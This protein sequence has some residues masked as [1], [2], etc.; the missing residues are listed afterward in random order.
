M[1]TLS[2]L[3]LKRCVANKSLSKLKTCSLLKHKCLNVRE[4]V[5]VVE[6][7]KMAP[8]LPLLSCE[9]SVSVKENPDRK[10]KQQKNKKKNI[11]KIFGFRG[12]KLFP[13]KVLTYHL[14]ILKTLLDPLGS[15]IKICFHT[16]LFFSFFIEPCHVDE[17]CRN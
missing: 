2:L 16:F 14:I 8:S 3:S 1:L 12:C 6:W 15:H 10:K 13:R 9:L 4:R 11:E 5:E 17:S 7:N